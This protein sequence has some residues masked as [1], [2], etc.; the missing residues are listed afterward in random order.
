MRKY[1][2]S[3]SVNSSHDL[4]SQPRPDIQSSNPLGY[5]LALI[6]VFLL[7]SIISY[8][9]YQSYRRNRHRRR[10]EM[11]ERI[12]EVDADRKTH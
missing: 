2:Q 7:A 8:K 12:W 3:L 4:N 9:S 1:T 5:L 10:I 6:P 11:L